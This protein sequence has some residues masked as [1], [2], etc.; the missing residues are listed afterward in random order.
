LLNLTEKLRNS[1]R[2]S[3]ASIGILTIA[4]TGFIDAV[5]SNEISFSIIYL[6]PITFVTWYAGRKI[7]IVMCILSVASWTF[8]DAY[9][10]VVY[11]SILIHI[12]NSFSRLAVSYL[13]VVLESSLKEHQ[14]KLEQNIIKK[15]ADLSIEQVE[16]RKTFESVKR[17][18]YFPELN[19][20]P[21]LEI[22]YD[23]K[24]TYCNNAASTFIEKL[25]SS[26]DHSIFF[27]DD[28][29]KIISS[30]QND[31]LIY[32]EKGAGNKFFQ[33]H[34]YIIPKYNTVQIY[35]T[36]ITERKIAE[37]SLKRSLKQKEMLLKEIHHRIKNNL[38]IVSS[39]LNLES[40][41]LKDEDAKLV[42]SETQNRITSL[43]T[44]HQMLYSGDNISE[45]DS[46]KF[47]RKL[48]TKLFEIYNAKSRTIIFRDEIEDIKISTDIANPM[49]LLITEIISNSLK[50]AF[51]KSGN[52][53]ILVSLKKFSNNNCEL[54]VRDNGIGFDRNLEEHKARIGLKL[55]E[56][57]S[58]QF[59]A[60][61]E[62]DTSSGTK[63]KLNF[64]LKT[65][66]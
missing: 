21:I 29:D 62:V 6:I 20:N 8:V 45:I 56:T 33:E 42:L 40:R 66:N 43:A 36:D 31:K 18:S 27:P 25:G 51:I 60:S 3:I 10:G 9:T 38:Q 37:E 55:V 26:A 28:I 4:V 30:Y 58:K 13:V 63:Y 7:G 12:W 1:S 19:P 16:H 23:K 64:K 47:F 35:A 11:S 32:R 52:N 2:L 15:T 17:L 24:L 61:C 57:L 34:I 39:L 49:G 5:T 46:V 22:D 65:T 59:K 41:T 44:V 14:L 53:E 48:V 54:I 50:Y